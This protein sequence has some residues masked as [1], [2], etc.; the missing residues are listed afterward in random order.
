MSFPSP[1][2]VNAMLHGDPTAI[3]AH[4]AGGG[5]SVN[6]IAFPYSADA[7]TPTGIYTSWIV[8]DLAGMITTAAGEDSPYASETIPN[9]DTTYGT[10]AAT[11]QARVTAFK[12]IIDGLDEEDDYATHVAA[13]ITQAASAY[14]TT[15]VATDIAAIHTA[16]RSSISTAITAA[17]AA[18]ATA[19]TAV[20]GAST[21]ALVTAY[22]AKIKKQYHASMARFT[23]GMADINAVNSS[24][25]IWGMAGIEKELLASIAE[26]TANLDYK[27][28]ELSETMRLNTLNT[29]MDAFKSTFLLHL[30]HHQSKTGARDK[31]LADSISYIGNLMQARLKY[32][33]DVVVQQGELNMLIHNSNLAEYNRNLELTVEDTLW[34]WKLY[35]FGGNMLAA[36]G[37]AVT[38]PKQM[39]AGAQAVSGAMS[40]A[41][42]GFMIGGPAGAAVGGIGGLLMGSKG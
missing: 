37:G 36:A 12:A 1:N 6:N 10:S 26:F 18:A 33:F 5:G 17:L 39:S 32:Q 14:P 13:A 27:A 38:I 41:S 24:A 23:S 20:T 31:F 7:T 42:L 4:A 34:D 8:T 28:F 22:E 2:A 30:T 16:E 3:Q 11:T 25:F 21:T 40:G 35:A 29:Y 19:A 9:H 15:S